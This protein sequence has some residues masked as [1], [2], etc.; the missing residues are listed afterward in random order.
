MKNILGL[1]PVLIICV[2]LLV[3][4]CG[5]PKAESSGVAIAEAKTMQTPQQK[6]DYLVGQAKAFYNS[7]QFQDTVDIAQYILRFLDKDSPD[8]VRFK[9]LKQIFLVAAS[10]EI[11]DRDSFLPLQF[12]KIARSLT[13]GE[14]ILL[15]TIWR[16][17]KERNF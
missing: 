7:K 10:E 17:S 13:D 11:S 1:I 3:S 14:V 8:E 15:T 16:I 9:I 12:M 5:A 6:M 2:S 4:G